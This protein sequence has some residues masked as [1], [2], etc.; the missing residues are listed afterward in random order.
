MNSEETPTIDQ[1]QH[2]FVHVVPS[3]PLHTIYEGE[4]PPESTPNVLGD[5]MNSHEDKPTITL[6]QNSRLRKWLDGRA[7]V[8]IVQG[9][10]FQCI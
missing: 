2:D 7:D 3:D 5:S 9:I 6:P 8:N 1:V 4:T 10:D